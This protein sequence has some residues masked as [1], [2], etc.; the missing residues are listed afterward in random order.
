[1]LAAAS[2]EH[3]R[4]TADGQRVRDLD[5]VAG[6][7]QL[8]ARAVTQRQRGVLDSVAD[9]QRPAGADDDGWGVPPGG[10]VGGVGLEDLDDTRQ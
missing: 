5:P 1:L 10:V 6:D 2:T 3:E 8:D 7:D 9:W 4:V